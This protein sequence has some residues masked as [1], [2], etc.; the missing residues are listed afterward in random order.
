MSGSIGFRP[1]GLI[2]NPTAEDLYRRAH[3]DTQRALENNPKEHETCA[4]MTH[5]LNRNYT[6]LDDRYSVAAEFY[7]NPIHGEKP[8]LL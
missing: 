5:I 1:H 6:L 7:P 3:I 8:I 2:T 4:L